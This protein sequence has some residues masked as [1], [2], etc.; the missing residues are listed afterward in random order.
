MDSKNLPRT[1]AA[2]GGQWQFAGPGRMP[3][4]VL[5]FAP[6]GNRTHEMLL[7]EVAF[8]GSHRSTVLFE[9]RSVPPVT[10]EGNAA[11]HQLA[12]GKKVLVEV[13][14]SG[15]GEARIVR[16]FRLNDS[17]TAK[18]TT[19]PALLPVSRP[20]PTRIN[21]V[22]VRVDAAF[23]FGFAEGPDGTRYFLPAKACRFPLRMN[24]MVNFTATPSL[25]GPLA[26]AIDVRLASAA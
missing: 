21:A 25:T 1:L 19:K 17:K 4:S 23:R 3:G 11:G 26:E 6:V 5:Y 24:T 16:W 22:I 18:P 9:N 2:G 20:S 14:F 15:P 7:G 12:V 13:T 10:I 8:A